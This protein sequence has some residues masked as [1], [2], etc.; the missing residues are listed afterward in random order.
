MS[1]L[2]SARALFREA[3]QRG[4]SNAMG[5]YAYCCELGLGGPKDDSVA[6]EWYHRAA[7]AGN[8]SAECSLGRCYADAI[9]VK[10]DMGQSLYWFLKAADNHNKDAIAEIDQR[11]LCHEL[12]WQ[13][14]FAKH[15][16]VRLKPLE[17]R[18][19]NDDLSFLEE[20]ILG[21]E[22]AC[23]ARHSDSVAAAVSRAVP[24]DSSSDGSATGMETFEYFIC[25]SARE[26]DAYLTTDKPLSWDSLPQITVK[27]NEIE[28]RL[29][30]ATFSVTAALGDLLEALLTT[31]RCRVSY[32]RDDHLWD[33][34][35]LRNVL[36]KRI[37]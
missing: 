6:L 5:K 13:L 35:W 27:R 37:P 15:Y 8:A 1:I 2:N 22:N 10:R 12:F 36:V 7:A 21:I 29:W 4:D 25:C 11:R 30:S 14:R 23:C 34:V 16:G 19:T 32:A 9:G 24:T 3:A 28:I 31:Y 17:S 33:A 18:L 26:R 20:R